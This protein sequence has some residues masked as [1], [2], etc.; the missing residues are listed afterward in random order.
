MHR[1][2][3]FYH[4]PDQNIAQTPLEKRDQSNLL[5]LNRTKKIIEHFS[6]RD[7]PKFLQTGDVLVLNNTRVLPARLYGQKPTGGNVEVLL[8]RRLGT[9]TNEQEEWEALTKPGLKVGQSVTCEHNGTS[10]TFTCFGID[11]QA[12]LLRA[13]IAGEE[14][15]RR[16]HALG[17]MPT[18]PYIRE[19]LQDPE[20]YQTVFGHQ[21]GSAAAPTASLHFTPS[22]LQE[23]RNLGVQI[24]EVTLHVSLATFLPVKA[25]EVEGHELHAEWFAIT[26]EAAQT[27]NQA[28]REGRRVIAVGTTATRTLEAAAQQGTPEELVPAISGETKIFLYPPYRFRVVDALI[29]NFHVPESTL[30]ML[31]AAFT[32]QPQT[33][34]VFTDFQS[35]LIG[36]AYAEALEKNYRFL[37]FGDAMLIL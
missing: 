3:F 1:A 32:T 33:D 34:E 31:V 19:K 23:L 9:S 12:R 22:L 16:L 24:V 21:E 37:S 5:V 18:P 2:Q 35:S 30:L 8:T 15:S 7:L 26:P 10:L 27:I 17:S 11:G 25:D 14:F 28:K 29:T 6:F 20:R 13:D 4:L 36:R